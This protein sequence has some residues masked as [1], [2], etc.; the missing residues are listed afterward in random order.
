MKACCWK[1]IN[2][3]AWLVLGQEM[4]NVPYGRTAYRSTPPIRKLVAAN[5][6]PTFVPGRDAQRI[7]LIVRNH[8]LDLANM[9]NRF[10]LTASVWNDDT[11]EF[12]RLYVYCW[13]AGGSREAHFTDKFQIGPKQLPG[14]LAANISPERLKRLGDKY[15]KL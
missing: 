9:R 5:Q 14:F 2:E 8:V 15:E 3:V 1:G 4:Q 6:C 7:R 10:A 11:N 13:H 12:L